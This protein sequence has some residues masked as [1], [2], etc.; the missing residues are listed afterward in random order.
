MSELKEL[1]P[2]YYEMKSEMD[3]YKKQCDADNAEIKRIMIE[4]K[5]L[6]ESADGY[7]AKIT[8]VEKEDF[9]EIKLLQKLKEI[10]KTECIK[11][12]EYVD[13]DVLENIIYNH[14]LDPKELADCKT[15]KTEYRLKVTKKEK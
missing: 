1:I 8:V 15:S 5:S 14:E 4:N 7:K 6:E 12:K 3:S 11:T 13:M 10:G 2:R 9:N